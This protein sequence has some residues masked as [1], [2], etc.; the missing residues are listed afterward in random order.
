MISE[1]DNDLDNAYQ[2]SELVHGHDEGA[3][4]EA[5]LLVVLGD[6]LQ[7][8]LPDRPA[9][10][11]FEDAVVRLAVGVFPLQPEGVEIGRREDVPEGA[12]GEKNYE[13]QR[14]HCLGIFTEGQKSE[15]LR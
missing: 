6:R 8:R 12:H 15:T 14:L 2:V 3:L 11:L 13:H 4:P 1:T 5:V 10:H 9:L 7:V